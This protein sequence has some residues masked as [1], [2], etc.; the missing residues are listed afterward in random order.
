MTTEMKKG[1]TTRTPQT[2]NEPRYIHVCRHTDLVI[3]WV[4]M[5]GFLA[6]PAC[7]QV[8]QVKVPRSVSRKGKTRAAAK[9][10]IGT[11]SP[12]LCG[13]VDDPLERGV[14]KFNRTYLLR[15]C[16]LSF[17]GDGE[18]SCGVAFAV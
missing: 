11:L 5:E 16:Y 12:P 14:N 4:E 7:H 13:G 10:N 9:I 6:L 18:G 17:E 3:L 1:Y 15:E 8:L 2:N